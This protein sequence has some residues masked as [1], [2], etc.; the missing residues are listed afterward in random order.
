M[1]KNKMEISLNI[2]N[3][4]EFKLL[5]KRVQRAAKELRIAMKELNKFKLRMNMDTEDDK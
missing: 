1:N 4:N 3:M 5:T 2:E